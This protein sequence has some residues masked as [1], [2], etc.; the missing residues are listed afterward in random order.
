LTTNAQYFKKSN[1]LIGFSAKFRLNLG[2]SLSAEIDVT[3]YIK[4]IGDITEKLS[5]SSITSGGVILPNLSLQLDNTRE[6]WNKNGDF[7]K[8]GFVNNSIFSIETSYEDINSDTGEESIAP[9]YKFTGLIKYISCVWDRT[10]YI[11]TVNL[12]HASN[13]LQT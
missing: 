8:N 5:T 10:D 1:L 2:N 13:L 7:F 12:I 11:L 9:S 4:N 6:K 3:K